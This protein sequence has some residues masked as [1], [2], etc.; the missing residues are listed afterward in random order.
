MTELEVGTLPWSSRPLVFSG[1]G[2]T[3]LEAMTGEELESA[4][5]DVSPAVGGGSQMLLAS[6]QQLAQRSCR[7]HE[8]NCKP[9]FLSDESVHPETFFPR[10]LGFSSPSSSSAAC[11]SLGTILGNTSGRSL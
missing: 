4:G 7:R 2:D 9:F 6:M 10:R 3:E 11:S 1:C 8:A 5:D